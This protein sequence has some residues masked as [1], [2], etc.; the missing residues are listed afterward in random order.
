MTSKTY[1][2]DSIDTLNARQFVIAIKRLADS[3]NY[4]T[5]A[6]PFVGGGIE[7]VQSRLYQ[8]GDNVKAIDWRVTARTGKYH[9]KEYE[10]PKR[11]PVYLLLDTSASMTIS[12]T[13]KSKYAHAVYIAGGLAFACLDRISP[14]ALIGV[15]EQ[16]LRYQ[17]SLSR[18]KIMQWLHR[19]RNYRVDEATT[20][21]MRINQLQPT[22]VDRS[23]L[24]VLSD[25][26]QPKAIA[27]LKKLAQQ[28]DCVAIQLIDPAERRVKGAGFFRGQEAESG[29]A[30]VSRGKRLG[31]DQQ[32]LADELKR[33]RVD[34]LALKIEQPV[35]FQLRHF[36]KSRGLLGA[37]AKS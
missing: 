6:S 15:G 5:D 17:P 25:L 12:S 34:H 36:F 1:Q 29:R 32:Q 9:V 26:H 19:L 14:V 2:L 21:A 33:A 37:G 22:L 10:S 13:I 3:L 11:M 16:D 4:G 28:H 18:D 35:D 8:P 31:I 24:I 23:L 27:P 7:Y 30:F 20:L